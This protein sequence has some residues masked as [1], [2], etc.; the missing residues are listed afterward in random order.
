MH[1]ADDHQDPR[2]PRVV[3]Q[4]DVQPT[5]RQS[6]DGAF[7]VL[8]KQL[9]ACT[10]AQQLGCSHVEVAPGKRAWP[11]HYHFGNEEALYVLEGEGTLLM[12][13]QPMPVAA[14]DYVTFPVGEAGAHQVWNT[15]SQP[16]RFLMLSTMR[17][18][19]I[20]MYPDSGKVGLFATRAPGTDDDGTGYKAYLRGDATME[21]WDGE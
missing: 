11:Y 20:T 9:G 3:R 12:A 4:Q 6:P 19:D 17:H 16:L 13:G 18:P 5:R 2:S 7:T 15:S 14:G 10:G 1:Q 21:Y 8:R